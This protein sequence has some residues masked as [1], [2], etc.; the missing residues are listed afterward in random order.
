MES[1]WLMRNVYLSLKES[2]LGALPI[3]G[4]ITKD[5]FLW[6]IYRPQ[7]TS[8]YWTSALLI[9]LQ[10]PSS[11]LKPEGTFTSFLAQDARCTTFSL[12]VSELH[13]YVESLTLSCMWG[14][15]MHVCNYIGLFSLVNLSNVIWLL[16]KPEES[17]R[18][19]ES[20]F[21]PHRDSQISQ[22]MLSVY[23]LYEK[24]Q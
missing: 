9:I 19:G 11:L 18:V 17:R 5:N 8:N 21:L 1:L 15:H 6:P 2:K 24:K 22:E 14:S 13:M 16:D 10:W 20:S 23:H 3:I 12:S 7:Q 4:V